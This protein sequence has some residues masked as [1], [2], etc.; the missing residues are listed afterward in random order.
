M[1]KHNRLSAS[2]A[3]IVGLALLTASCAVDGGMGDADGL[4]PPPARS[5]DAG[6]LGLAPALRPFYDELAPHGDWILVEPQG[7]VFRPR[8][9]TVAWR[10]YRDGHWEPS[11]TYG[12]VWESNDEFGWITDHYGFWFHDDFQGWVWQPYGAWAPSWVAW[13]QVGDYVGWA[14][15]GPESAPESNN[16]PGGVFT[17]VSLNSLAQPSAAAHAS[18]VNSVPVTDTDMTPIDR[19]ASYRGVYWNAG[20]DLG[21]VLGTP[22]AERLRL[23]E[24]DQGTAA[25]EPARSPLKEP[26][27][28][29]SDALQVRT[30]RAVRVAQRELRVARAQA[31]RPGGG[32]PSAPPA[33]RRLKPG[34]PAPVS[35]T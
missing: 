11:W 8:V 32:T 33:E 7:W 25:I 23:T 28:L 35:Y 26:R 21:E 5:M 20:P 6:R 10:P 19:V 2:H 3:L 4:P 16:V 27:E 17:Y 30:A 24:R 29:G 14:P 15:L 13:V 1:F 12:W 9:N 18:Y 31:A 34:E 22:A